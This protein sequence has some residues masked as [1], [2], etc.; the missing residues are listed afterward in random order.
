MATFLFDFISIA[1]LENLPLG[2][3]RILLG[4]FPLRI[5][6]RGNRSNYRTLWKRFDSSI[7]A[8]AF[9]YDFPLD[10]DLNQNKISLKKPQIMKRVINI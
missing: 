3:C 8:I 4:L 6:I 10:F 9:N 1:S 2:R 7:V 5:D